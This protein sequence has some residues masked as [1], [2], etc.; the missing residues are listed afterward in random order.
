MAED[1]PSSKEE[2]TYKRWKTKCPWLT[3]ERED[4]QYYLGCSECMGKSSSNAKRGFAAGRNSIENYFY[5]RTLKQH[6]ASP[7]HVSEP[8]NNP[9]DAQAAGP[10][11]QTPPRSAPVSP[12]PTPEAAAK[13]LP[14]SCLL[15]TL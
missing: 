6:V 7:I 9:E 4:E 12:D 15:F 13:C 5:E 10:L 3:L 14:T 11:E 1:Q 2:E 8:S